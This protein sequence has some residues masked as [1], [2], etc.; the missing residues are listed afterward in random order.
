M[1]EY[2]IAVMPGVQVQVPCSKAAE[3]RQGETEIQITP[4]HSTSTQN[5]PGLA[6]ESNERGTLQASSLA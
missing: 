5:K 6:Q 1:E 2:S 4:N 3:Q